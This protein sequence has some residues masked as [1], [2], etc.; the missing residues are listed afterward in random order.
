MWARSAA[1]IPVVMPSRASTETVYAVFFRSWLVWYIGGS[2]SR[3]QS[4]PVSGTQTH[5]AGVPDRE[6]Q[7]LRRR[8]LGGEDQVAFVLPVGVVDDDDRASGRDVGDRPLHAGRGFLGHHALTPIGCRDRI[9]QSRI[10]NRH[11]PR[12]TA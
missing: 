6:R 10:P 7:Q 11:M 12:K 1:E 4:S 8:L 3:S 5:P 2:S 9:V